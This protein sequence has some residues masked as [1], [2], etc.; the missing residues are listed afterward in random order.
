MDENKQKE[1]LLESHNN[2]NGNKNA[3]NISPEVPNKKKSF[4][5]DFS[6]IFFFNYE[7][8]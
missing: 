3:E 8:E 6:V 2:D 4:G 1:P 7:Y 5:R